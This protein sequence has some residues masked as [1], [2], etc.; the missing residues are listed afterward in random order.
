VHEF[1]DGTLGVSHQG[2]LLARF[3]IDGRLA[4]PPRRKAA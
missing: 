2:R 4:A 3:G 1:L